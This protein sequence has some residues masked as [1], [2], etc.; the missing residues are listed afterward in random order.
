MPRRALAAPPAHRA[1][2]RRTGAGGSEARS[3]WRLSLRTAGSSRRI[4]RSRAAERRGL[5]CRSDRVAVDWEAERAA[6]GRR[7][8]SMSG[9]RAAADPRRCPRRTAGGRIAVVAGLSVGGCCCGLHRSKH[10][11]VKIDKWYCAADP[12]NVIQTSDSLEE[13][14]YKPKRIHCLLIHETLNSA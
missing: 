8:R 13:E 2:P 12:K 4:R 11:Q 7:G 10:R 9:V 3:V 5:R 14:N 6:C 1:A